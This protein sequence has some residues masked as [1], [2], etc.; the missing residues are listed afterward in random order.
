MPHGGV[1]GESGDK[2]GNAGA[3]FAP[4]CPRHCGDYVGRKLRPPTVH[5]V[6]YASPPEGAEWAAPRYITV[7]QGDGTKDMT[8]DGDGDAGEYG[9]GV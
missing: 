8:A 2:D 7:P 4:A 1:P 5:P 6:Q 3:L 9:V